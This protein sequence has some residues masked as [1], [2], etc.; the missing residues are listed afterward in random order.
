M[1][2]KRALHKKQ[3]SAFHQKQKQLNSEN[4]SESKDE[5]NLPES[6]ADEINDTFKDVVLP[7]KRKLDNLY[8]P[9]A[10]KN[11]IIKDENF[12]PYAAADKH[13]EEG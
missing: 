13:T 7:K 4:I 1:K 2:E 9:K 8:K 12:I 6:N 10:K 5:C 3:I 11:K